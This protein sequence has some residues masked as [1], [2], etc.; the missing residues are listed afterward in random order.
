[1]AIDN[2][3]SPF[4]LTTW[5]ASGDVGVRINCGG[6]I[7]FE[8]NNS[9]SLFA[10]QRP[11]GRP[12]PT[13]II[14]KM[15]LIAA[16]YDSEFQCVDMINVIDPKSP[17]DY[18]MPTMEFQ[19]QEARNLIE[20][21]GQ[22]TSKDFQIWQGRNAY[23]NV[24]KALPKG[25]QLVPVGECLP[26][27][28]GAVLKL[29]L[30]EHW[31][32]FIELDFICDL[33]K[34]HIFMCSFCC[35][36]TLYNGMACGSFDCVSA[37]STFEALTKLLFLFRSGS[38]PVDDLLI[39]KIVLEKIPNNGSASNAIEKALQDKSRIFVENSIMDATFV[40]SSQAGK[41]DLFFAI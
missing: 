41:D 24:S 5:A 39:S 21:V 27:G 22:Y 15:I 20:L 36:F 8:N 34:V 28:L 18:D 7:E 2:A 37:A 35:V 13:H 38:L 26:E 4:F 31:G 10:F 17:G 30:L 9:N 23:S 1:M 16:G 11:D 32:I 14:I 3:A 29:S 19:L 12:V 6:P 33:Q 40:T 25:S